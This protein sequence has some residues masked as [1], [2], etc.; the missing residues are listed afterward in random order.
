MNKD[1][2]KKYISDNPVYYASSSIPKSSVTFFPYTHYFRGEYLSS[3]PKIFDRQAGWYI[4]DNQRKSNCSGYRECDYEQTPTSVCF[5]PPCSTIP[6]F[7][8]FAKPGCYCLTGS[9]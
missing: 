4:H 9:P 6:R 2:I 5:Q 7:N 8:C 3:D 1:N